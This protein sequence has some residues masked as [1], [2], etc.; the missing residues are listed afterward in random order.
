MALAQLCKS[1]CTCLHKH[2]NTSIAKGRIDW[3][4]IGRDS[5][6]FW[7]EPHQKQQILG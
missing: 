7:F 3:Q 6:V 4:G 2:P 1:T 5:F